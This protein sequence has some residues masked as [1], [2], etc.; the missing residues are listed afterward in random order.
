MAN[1][2]DKVKSNT[3]HVELLWLI[4]GQ[5]LEIL[6]YFFNSASGHSG[7]GL[8]V[9]LRCLFVYFPSFH[10]SATYCFV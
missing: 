7:P 5:L 9:I 3:F 2:W 1:F 4:F 10:N 8:V 6:G